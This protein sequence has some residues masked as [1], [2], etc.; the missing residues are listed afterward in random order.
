MRP[1]ISG[2]KTSPTT[3]KPMNATPRGQQAGVGQSPNPNK[4]FASNAENISKNV[5][6]AQQREITGTPRHASDSKNGKPGQNPDSSKVAVK[7]HGSGGSGS[8]PD[9]DDFVMVPTDLTKDAA[10]VR[11]HKRDSFA[12][13]RVPTANRRH[14]VSGTS[15]LVTRPSHLPGVGINQNPQNE[16]I[17]VPTQK[18][19]YQQIQES[20]I[21]SR[22]RSGESA[23]SG[24]SST[25]SEG[26]ST[27]G[28]LPEE[29]TLRTLATASNRLP[30]SG[31]VRKSPTSSPS[32]HLKSRRVS[33]P[34]QQ[35]PAICQ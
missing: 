17:P 28:P 4:Q 16:P 35:I 11:K 31:I 34:P 9:Q 22:T 32:H 12:N 5:V 27:L 29:G 33:A 26:A 1:G 13:N 18:L 3:P 23:M 2:R 19:A 24:I 14:T 25:G 6:H 10:E 8:S 20:L 30:D 21:R 15:P 7:R